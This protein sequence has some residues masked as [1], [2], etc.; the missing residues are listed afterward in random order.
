VVAV[1][2]LRLPRGVSPPSP[3]SPAVR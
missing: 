3:P 1:L 2:A